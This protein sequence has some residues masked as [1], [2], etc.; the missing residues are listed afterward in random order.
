[1]RPRKRFGQHFLSPEWARKVV[2]AIAPEAGETLLEIG[3]GRGALTVPLAARAGRVV[4][5]EIDRDL[6][7]DLQRTAPA[8]VSV[9]AGDFLDMDLEALVRE[10]APHGGLR[11]AGNLPYNVSSPIL[12]RLIG[13]H[14]ATGLLRD[15]TVMLQREVVERLAARAGTSEY[16]VLTIL[17]RLYADVKTV[18]TLPPGAFRPAPKVWSAVARLSFTPPKV[19][20]ADPALFE[21]VVK[22]LFS[23]RRKKVLN[24]LKPLCED[25]GAAQALLAAA[26]IDPARRPETLDLPELAALTQLLGS[27]RSRAV[28]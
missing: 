18:L 3:P 25:A 2:D 26:G 6:A 24:A 7:A 16:G 13:V 15:A 5:V 11:I 27:G 19:A 28:L 4:A 21:R 14:R 22:G 8:N 9:V 23:Q 10:H 1:M 12:F 20:V 17:T